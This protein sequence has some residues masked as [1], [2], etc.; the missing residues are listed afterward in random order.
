M[1]RLSCTKPI[2]PCTRDHFM[3][4]NPSRSPLH[5]LLSTQSSRRKAGAYAGIAAAALVTTQTGMAAEQSTPAASPETSGAVGLA[6]WSEQLASLP[7]DLIAERVL[8]QEVAPAYFNA[9]L[10]AVETGFSSEPD[11]PFPGEVVS[12]V[13]LG[14]TNPSTGEFDL[15]TGMLLMFADARAAASALESMQTGQDDDAMTWDIPFAGLDGRWRVWADDRTMIVLRAG[16]VILIGSDNFTTIGA[17]EHLMDSVFNVLQNTSHV[18][19]HLYAAT[20]D[21]LGIG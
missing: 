3:P 17:R 16:P 11:F 15:Q 7:P 9:E 18:L 19:F 12:E 21:D 8:A 2:E 20:N 13:S 5:N 6:I 1:I 4:V 10:E 14:S